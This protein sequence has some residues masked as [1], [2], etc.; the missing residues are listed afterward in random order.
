MPQRKKCAT[1]RFGMRLSTDELARLREDADNAGITVSELLRRRALQRPVQAATD[2]TMIRELRR[3]GGLQ[4]H[5]INKSLHDRSI[6]DE[7]IATIKTLRSA[8][9]R[10]ARLDC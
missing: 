5:M 9:E 7:C 3:L 8:I 6:V 2:L 10:L 4:K 1:A